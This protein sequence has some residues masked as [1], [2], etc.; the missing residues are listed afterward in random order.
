[1]Q[2]TLAEYFFRFLSLLP[3]SMA[4]KIGSAIGHIAYMLPNSLK[5]PLKINI[6]LCFPDLSAAERA[7]LCK[8]S[9][10]EMCKGLAEGGAMFTWDSQRLLNLVKQVSGE[11]HL[12][13]GLDKGK[14]VILA[15]PHLGCW[16]ILSV[17]CPT[18][19]PTTA[20]YRPLRLSGLDPFIKQARERFGTTPVP[21]NATGI[22]SLYKAL[23]KNEV[24]AILPDQDP[25][26]EGGVFAPF[27]G[28]SAS[29]MTLVPR[30]IDKTGATLV[31]GYAERLPNGTGYNI[32]F[33]PEPND[34]KNLDLQEATKLL[35][36]GVERCVQQ[37]PEQYLWVYKR[38]KTRPEGEPSI[39]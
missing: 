3:L 26:R 13:Q 23:N 32:H 14:G 11:E 5:H 1:M 25:G 8:N 15:L 21:T 4:H 20:L 9:F 10:I 18:H 22:R 33:L 35:N 27:C 2:A 7:D 6:D 38:F 17:Y 12:K 19:Y 24:V 34:F 39:Y 37:S 28:I 31:Y 29:T 16:E 30:L 36:Q